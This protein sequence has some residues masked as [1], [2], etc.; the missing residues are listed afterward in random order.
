MHA[1]VDIKMRMSFTWVSFF[2]HQS[3]GSQRIWYIYL[4][5]PLS[6]KN[7]ETID[8]C[9]FCETWVTVKYANAIIFV[10]RSPSETLLLLFVT[11]KVIQQKMVFFSLHRNEVITVYQEIKNQLAFHLTRNL[12][13]S[14]SPC[15]MYWRHPVTAAPSVFGK[16]SI[17]HRRIACTSRRSQILVCT[18]AVS[19]T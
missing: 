3:Q 10:S 2:D 4:F 19:W 12:H 5:D 18:W 6:S 1:F 7:V 11:L 15:Y 13:A 8:I 14:Q 16:L 17:G 9:R